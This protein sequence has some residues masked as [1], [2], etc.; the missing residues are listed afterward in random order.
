MSRAKTA[1]VCMC[2]N[3]TPLGRV[4]RQSAQLAQV[5]ELKYLGRTL[6]ND[7]DM[8]TEVRKRTHR[9]WN[10][11]RRM[12][13][14]LFDKRI[15]PHEKG[16]IHNMIVQPAKLHGMETVPMTSAHLKE[17]GSNRNEDAQMATR[18]QTK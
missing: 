10:N 13:G 2:L 4:N 3:G 9:G 6:K 1:R 17:T 18:P 14:V 11:W 16:N 5:T 8:N 15:T 7:G 12:T